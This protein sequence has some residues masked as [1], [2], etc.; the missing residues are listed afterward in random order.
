[1]HAGWAVFVNSLET[2]MYSP[3]RHLCRSLTWLPKPQDT[4]TDRLTHKHACEL[5]SAWLGPSGAGR[6]WRLVPAPASALGPWQLL[7]GSVTTADSLVCSVWA[8]SSIQQ[9]S[10]CSGSREEGFLDQGLPAQRRARHGAAETRLNLPR[11]MAVHAWR[12]EGRWGRQKSGSFSHA[13]VPLPPTTSSA[14][15]PP[16]PVP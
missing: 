12:L 4:L 2:S 6:R 3:S 7:P 15:V 14:R 10:G 13:K 9:G 8:S 11:G 5:R 1:M 16:P